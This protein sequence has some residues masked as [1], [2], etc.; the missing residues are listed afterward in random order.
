MTSS[1][2]H[3]HRIADWA[4]FA[5]F[6]VWA[7]LTVS[8][9]PAGG[10]LLA[11]AF[12]F[13]V[14]VAASFLMRDAPKA[15]TRSLRSRFTAYG[16][17][18]VVLIF[19]QFAGSSHPEWFTPRINAFTP[20]AIALWIGGSLWTVWAVYHLRH[21]F[22][23]EPAARRL[24]T[25]GPYRVARHPVYSGYY[26]QYLGMWMTFP[27]LP[28]LLVL[29]VWCGMMVDRMYQ[30]EAVL[31]AAFPEYAAY[32]R[33]VGALGPVFRRRRADRAVVSA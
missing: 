6:G 30:E 21:A 28:F 22:S 25:S 4:G 11:P 7:G 29:L 17:S 13:E 33:R 24:V 2:V 19:L 27:S 8:N 16:G 31:R 10:I 23:I 5:I 26:A 9:M 15:T 20:L 18:F 1:P 12:L 14:F 3:F 32:A